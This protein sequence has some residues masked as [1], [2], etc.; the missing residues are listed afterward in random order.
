VKTPVAIFYLVGAFVWGSGAH[1]HG[2]GIWGSFLLAFSW[3]VIVSA[4]VAIDFFEED[5]K[6]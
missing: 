4:H 3:P 2:H 1:Y 5:E 6:E